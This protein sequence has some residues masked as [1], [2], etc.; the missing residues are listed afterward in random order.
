MKT[1]ARVL[2]GSQNY[3]LDGIDSD[4]DYKLLMAPEFEDFYNYH[5]IDKKD[6]PPQYDSK[7]YGIMDVL[8]FD[9][10]LQKGNFNALEMLFSKEIHFYDEKIMPYINMAQAFFENG[11]I[12]SVWTE[13][14]HS[15][16]GIIKSPFVREGFTRKTASRALYILNFSSFIAQNKF[17][18]TKDTWKNPEIYYD[19]RRLRFN[20]APL[21]DKSY[22]YEKLTKLKQDTLN[23]SYYSIID[24]HKE[25]SDEMKTY[26]KSVLKGEKVYE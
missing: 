15:I 10:N 1:V 26:I 16:E 19:A 22:Y 11:F 6:L 3:C 2:I 13:Y 14:L 18:I 12:L 4:Y 17:R 7:H 5:R 8:T 20:D 21:Y 25:L 24:W 9:H 23:V